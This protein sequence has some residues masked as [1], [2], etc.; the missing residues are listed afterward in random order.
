MDSLWDTRFSECDLFCPIRDMTLIL[1]EV[2]KTLGGLNIPLCLITMIS[3]YMVL[4]L[5][6]I[7]VHTANRGSVFITHTFCRYFSSFYCER[8]GLGYLAKKL[9][10]TN[11]DTSLGLHG[12]RPDENSQSNV[13]FLISEEQT[14]FEPYNEKQMYL[15]LIP[16]PISSPRAGE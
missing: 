16:P 10:K 2:K 15:K 14:E 8:H 9:G 6:C 4:S 13:T 1:C 11:Y 5:P 12:I 3:N 7:L